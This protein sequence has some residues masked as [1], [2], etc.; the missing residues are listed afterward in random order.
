MSE[1]EVAEPCQGVEDAL[2]PL[3]VYRFMESGYYAARSQ[4]GAFEAVIAHTGCSAEELDLENDFCSV[5]PASEPITVRSEDSWDDERETFVP[6][7]GGYTHQDGSPVGLYALTLTAAEW[8]NTRST[9]EYRWGWD[10]TG[11]GVGYLFGGSE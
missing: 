7:Q 9:L 5:V 8:A 2:G 1:V 6:G 11:D 10:V 4:A 3:H